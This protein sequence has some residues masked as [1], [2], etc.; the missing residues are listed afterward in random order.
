MFDRSQGEFEFLENLKHRFKNPHIGD[1]CAVFPKDGMADQLISVDLL[2]EEIDFRLE[3]TTG[4]QLGHKALAVSLS[5]IAA[6]AGT[7]RFALLSIGVPQKLWS[8][9]FLDDLYAGWHKLAEQYDVELV[10]GDISRTPERFVIDS[11]VIG[12]CPCGAAVPRSAAKPG[13]QI[14]VTGTLGAAAAGLRMLMDD[15]LAGDRVDSR[16]RL[17]SRQLTPQ[18]R[19]DFA[20]GVRGASAMIDVSDGLASDLFHICR[21]SDVGAVIDAGNLPIDPDIVECFPDRTTQLDLALNGGEDFEL[22]F[23]ANAEEAKGATMIGVITD[24]VQGM[25]IKVD[26]VTRPLESRGFRHF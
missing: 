21:A 16:R 4:A 26:G 1:D 2:V 20:P 15:T 17:I 7:A 8:T 14:F 3:W 6:M 11:I 9:G 12:E 22:L 23:T 18:P 10:G 24:A 5:D 25:L 19:L 13:D